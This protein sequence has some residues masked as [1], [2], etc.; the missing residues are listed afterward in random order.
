MTGQSA[1]GNDGVDAPLVAE[2]Q[3]NHE[4]ECRLAEDLLS[5]FWTCREQIAERTRVR[6][7][8]ERT[9]AHRLSAIGALRSYRR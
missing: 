6:G 1:A 9:F 8:G 4:R 2:F 3:A 7:K 5:R